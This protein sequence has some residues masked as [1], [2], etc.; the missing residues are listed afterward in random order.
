[1]AFILT[2]SFTKFEFMGKINTFECWI[3]KLL[4]KRTLCVLYVTQYVCI[5]KPEDV[6]FLGLDYWCTQGQGQDVT[7]N[8]VCSCP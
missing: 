8:F 7:L 2:F 4:V 1:M 3:I 6:L 5:H